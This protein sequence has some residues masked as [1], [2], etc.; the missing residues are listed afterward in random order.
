MK[1]GVWIFSAKNKV[2]LQELSGW[3]NTGNMIMVFISVVS[4]DL[5]F[6]FYQNQ[7]CAWIEVSIYTLNLVLDQTSF[8]N[9][10][11]QYDESHFYWHQ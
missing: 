4:L 6:S 10:S 5:L 8:L 3:L 2:T 11:V 1:L 9:T 7:K